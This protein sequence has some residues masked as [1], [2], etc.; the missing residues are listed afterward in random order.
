VDLETK[1]ISVVAVILAV[2]FLQHLIRREDPL[3]TLQFG[4]ALAL[5]SG[6]RVLFQWN[7]RQCN[8]RWRNSGLGGMVL[9]QQMAFR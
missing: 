5:V 8:S 9:V 3:A 6:V 1:V 7:T 4:A 2:T